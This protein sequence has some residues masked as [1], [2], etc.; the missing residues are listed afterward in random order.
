MNL[1]YPG[2]DYRKDQLVYSFSSPPSEILRHLTLQ[3]RGRSPARPSAFLAP[4]PSPSQAV[5]CHTAAWRVPPLLPRHRHVHT[6]LLLPTSSQCGR[7][8][9]FQPSRPSGSPAAL[10]EPAG[11]VVC[12]EPTRSVRVLVWS[13][14]PRHITE[15]DSE[16]RGRLP[17]PTRLPLRCPVPCGLC[18]GG[19]GA[20]WGAERLSGLCPGS[21][22][23][24]PCAGGR[25]VRVHP[26]AGQ[27]SA[28]DAACLAHVQAVGMRTFA[29]FLGVFVPGH[30]WILT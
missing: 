14:P 25:P 15:T 22:S 23:R 28:S 17:A 27:G 5:R 3:R 13:R 20:G 21:A 12:L 30:I 9:W 6:V 7:L 1:I 4:P 24:P 18:C 26:R 10:A 8:A 16:G 19:A 11:S 2:E 29:F